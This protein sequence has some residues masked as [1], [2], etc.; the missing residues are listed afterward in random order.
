[1]TTGYGCAREECANKVNWIITRISPPGTISACDE[2]MPMF[3][4]PLLAGEL[5]VDPGR[6]YDSV[7]RF[8]DREAARLAKAAAAAPGEVVAVDTDSVMIGGE[9]QA[10]GHDEGQAGEANPGVP[11]APGEQVT[12]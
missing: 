5:G 4:I 11:M 10:D 9:G 1:M 3:I 7:K 12:L 8:T 2:D 6:L